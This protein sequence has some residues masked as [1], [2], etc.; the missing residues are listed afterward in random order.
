LGKTVGL[1][2]A[3]KPEWLNK[4][5]ELVIQVEDDAAIKAALGEYLSFEI[6]SEINRGKTRELLM[7]IWARPEETSS[8]VQR[9]ALDAFQIDRSDNI[10]LHWALFVLAH[11]LFADASCLIGKI[12]T[13]QDTFT[14]SWLKARLCEQHGERP[15]LIRAVAGI[16]ETMRL[17]DCIHQEKIGVYRIKK[18]SVRDEQT[19]ITMLMTLLALERKAYYEISELLCVPLFFPFEFNVSVE[20]LHNSP[21]FTIENFGG[22][23]VLSGNK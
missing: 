19:I 21:E 20:W 22:K 23:M 18:Q 13:I 6:G 10:A 9:K 5:A 4:A 1:F 16:L 2:R 8:L 7:N 3:I 17:L 14:T 12:A 11:P 15:T